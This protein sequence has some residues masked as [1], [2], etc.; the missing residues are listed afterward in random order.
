MCCEYVL[1]E[2]FRQV[3]QVV[4]ATEGKFDR[5]LLCLRLLNNE[6][7]LITR[8]EGTGRLINV[9]RGERLIYCKKAIEVVETES[10]ELASSSSSSIP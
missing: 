3:R 7:F 6:E 10:D 2:R 8:S 4:F 5:R 1:E 9:E